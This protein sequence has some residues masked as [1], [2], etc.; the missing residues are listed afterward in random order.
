M[1]VFKITLNRVRLKVSLQI[2]DLS[3]GFNFQR[4]EFESEAQFLH[5]YPALKFLTCKS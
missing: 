2:A 1:A 5:K 3:L 4:A